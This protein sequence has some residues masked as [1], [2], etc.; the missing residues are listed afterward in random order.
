MVATTSQTSKQHL[1]GKAKQKLI[2]MQSQ[3]RIRLQRLRKPISSPEFRPQFTSKPTRR[4]F[5]DSADSFDQS[6]GQRVSLERVRNMVPK[7]AKIRNRRFK[8]L[9]NSM[10]KTKIE[11]RQMLNR[12]YGPANSAQKFQAPDKNSVARSWDTTKVLIS[13]NR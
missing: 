9:P 6:G 13:L 4:K 7:H 2:L 10:Q 5:S 11:Q 1:R 3:C 8:K 12:H